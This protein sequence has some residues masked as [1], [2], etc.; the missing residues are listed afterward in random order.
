MSLLQYKFLS[1]KLV[2][3]A[4]LIVPNVLL[5]AGILAVDGTIIQRD[6]NF[7]LYNENFEGSYFPLWNDVTSQTNIERFPR[8]VMM[9]PF[10]MLSMLGIE[11]SFIAKIMIVSAFAFATTTTYLF[12]TSLIHRFNIKKGKTVWIKS[13]SIIGAYI[14]AYSPATMQ[15][16]WEI[17]FI[18]SMAILPLMLY[19][20]TSR[21]TS[22]YLPLFLAICLLFSFAHPLFLIMN[23]IVSIFFMLLINY[24]T[25]SLRY[26]ISKIV[27]TGVIAIPLL[28]W[29][30]MPY[31]AAPISSIELGRDEH[32]ERGIFDTVSENDFYKIFFLERDRFVYV[33]TAP[34]DPLGGAF[35]YASLSLLVAG[36]FACFLLTQRWFPK[37]IALFFGGGFLTLTLISLGSKGPLGELYWLFVSESGIGWII[38]SPLKFQLYQA[39]F[40]SMLF[41]VSIAIIRQRIYPK[42]L[43]GIFM[44]FVLVGSSYYSIYHAVSTSLNP[45]QIPTEYHVI[46]SYL[47]RRGSDSKVLYLPRYNELPTLWSQ[48]HMIAPFDMKSSRIPT[49]D[50]Y[51]GYNFV[52]ETLYDYPFTT[53]MLKSD[54]FYELLSSVGVSYIVYHNDRGYSLDQRNLDSLL[55]SQNLALLFSENGWYLFELKNKPVEKIRAVTALAE[56][57]DI[58]SRF[59]LASPS[60]GVIDHSISSRFRNIIPEDST[61]VKFRKSTDTS[62]IPIENE[63]KDANFDAFD[64]SNSAS[65][66]GHVDGF[67]VEKK[68]DEGTGANYLEIS[69]D[70][71][72]KKSWSWLVND[73]LEVNPGET[74]LFTAEIKTENVYGSHVK[75]QGLDAVENQWKDMVF[76][77]SGN[78]VSSGVSISGDSEWTSY[79]KT[80]EIPPDTDRI[81]YVI[82]AGSVLDETLGPAKT[83]ARN[84]GVYNLV[85]TSIV[86]SN[87]LVKEYK[88]ITSTEYQVHISSDRPFVLTITE[89]YDKGWVAVDES[90]KEIQSIPL[91]GMINGFYIE[92]TGDYT[93]SIKYK[94]QEFFQIG[95]AIS[96]TTFFGMILYFL[97]P[98]ENVVI[99][100]IS[101]LLRTPQA[102]VANMSYKRQIIEQMNRQTSS[103]NKKIELNM[104]DAGIANKEHFLPKTMDQTKSG[105]SRNHLIDN[106]LSKS[107]D[108]ISRLKKIDSS[109]I[110]IILGIALLMIIPA[111]I[112]MQADFLNLISAYAMGCLVIG[113]IWRTIL[114]RQRLS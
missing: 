48:G 29:L 17:S 47:E 69:T 113:V 68:R 14:F 15:F 31:F 59:S 82:N 86:A 49:Y 37:R 96:M 2:I 23:A 8:L 64:N 103:A 10:I 63:I 83:L 79:W 28:A 36:A 40:L 108:L 98:S 97:L 16:S 13:I 45:I 99:K 38:R 51:L 1:K 87:D 85:E 50:T 12:A 22:R 46:N 78:D 65:W 53:G 89:A 76:I 25:L 91:Y 27:L 32:L 4:I 30:W 109:N 107:A 24:R 60:M 100:R 106:E 35:H 110:P 56:V 42:T 111:L 21:P 74:Y 6:F 54:D 7:P 90:G 81:R 39:F 93:L 18:A 71:A 20:I 52:K 73:E 19:F 67:E 72:N 114:H 57:D 5:W 58:S 95:A 102:I 55:Q 105:N 104:T 70:S 80:L 88:Q 61:L 112:G 101:N 62:Q 26:T 3:P 33:D 92:Q 75:V 84:P 9:S 66:S 11:V 94:P 34:D 44:I 77:T 43:V 41:I